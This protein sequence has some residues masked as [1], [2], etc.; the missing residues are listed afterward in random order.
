MKEVPTE[1]LLPTTPT[2]SSMLYYGSLAC[3][4]SR[5]GC[6]ERIRPRNLLQMSPGPKLCPVA[7]FC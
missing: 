3:C 6:L 2:A 5:D 1:R 4:P 7:D